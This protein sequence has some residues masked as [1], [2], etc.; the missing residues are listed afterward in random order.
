MEEKFNESTINRPEGERLLDAPFVIADLEAY[1]RQITEEDAWFKNDRN[2]ITLFKSDNIT[3]VLIALH[4]TAQLQPPSP[5]VG[6]AV[7][8]VLSGEL[9]VEIEGQTFTI[10]RH[11]IVNFH[12]QLQYYIAAKEESIFLLTMYNRD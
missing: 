8:Q 1:I 10:K 12:E 5:S 11:Q 6:I 9:T 7:I 2:A 4:E 3:V